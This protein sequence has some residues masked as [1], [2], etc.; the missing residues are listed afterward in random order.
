MN[1]TSGSRYRG[2]NS[3]LARRR[4]Q[5]EK[6]EI[7]K[8]PAFDNSDLIEKF[9]LTLV[10]RIVGQ[11]LGIYD[12]ADVEGGRVRVFVNG[13]N[14]LKFECK[15]GFD[16]G[17]VVKATIIYEDLYRHCFT[18]KRIS[19]EEGTCPEL[20]ENQREHNRIKRIE[21]K[22]MEERATKEA[23]SL[24]QRQ[25]LI[26]SEEKRYTPNDRERDHR[27]ETHFS[28]SSY[29]VWNNEKENSQDLRDELQ[30]R[31]DYHSKNVWKRLDKNSKPE[32][33]RNRERFHP[34]HHNSYGYPKEKTRDTASSLEWRVREPNDRRQ[35]PM[36]RDTSRNRVQLSRGRN[37]VSPDLQRTIS[38]NFRRSPQKSIYRG[39]YSHSPPS[40]NMEWRPVNK[41]PERGEGRGER[42]LSM[43]RTRTLER[44]R[45][46]DSARHL[47]QKEKDLLSTPSGKTITS[48]TADNRI[49]RNT[50]PDKKGERNK[51]VDNGK[52]GIEEDQQLM[53]E[54]E[55]TQIME[56]YASVDL[57]MDDDMVDD[58]DLLD[59]M[60]DEDAAVPETQEVLIQNK[61]DL[62]KKGVMDEDTTAKE[63][64]STSSP[65]AGLERVTKSQKEKSK[66]DKP[67]ASYLHKHR[68]AKSP[69]TKG[70]AASRK[71]ASRGRVSPKGKLVRHGRPS[72]MGSA[73][74]TT[75]PRFGV[76]P[77]AVR[78]R[79]LSSVS[80]SV[81]S[82]KPPSTQI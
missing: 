56:E 66:K 11:A 71:L 39:R 3:H 48:E 58:D 74:S 72:A 53:S 14:P 7:I 4:F 29:R 51:T 28:S 8:V 34:Y 75:I 21:Q 10:G 2:D 5:E 32:Y 67:Q 41:N 23:F 42:N 15:V 20:T 47:P 59:D 44:T 81:G 22:E 45:T 80:G 6:D 64:R 79:K 69:D 24:P 73:Q 49:D 46:S 36:K 33:P 25:N 30:E 50:R 78:S 19:H 35:D 57:E 63:M 61:K 52:Q 38:D 1:R 17:D 40:R 60:D 43:E 77:S 70:L 12:K 26:D 65:A 9:K 31:R 68:G 54:E 13:D 37:R 55:I 82:K 27:K 16:N 76:Y 62:S 18:C